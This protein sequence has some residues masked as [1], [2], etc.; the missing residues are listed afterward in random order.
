MTAPEEFSRN[1]KT[2]PG[3]TAA[4]M[5]HR[6]PTTV[7]VRIAAFGT[8][9]G[10][11]ETSLMGASRRPARTNSI[12]DA[13]YRPEFRQ[14]RTAVSTTAFMIVAAYGIPIAVNALTYGD[15]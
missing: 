10:L 13:V 6:K 7:E 1:R 9:R 5:T 2:P 12:R 8:P 3:E 4:A 15:A 11:S 14:D